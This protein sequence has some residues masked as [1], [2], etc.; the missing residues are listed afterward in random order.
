MKFELLTEEEHGV[1][2]KLAEVFGD[3]LDIINKSSNGNAH[4]SSRGPDI[5]EVVNHIHALQN[6]VLAQ[7]AARRYPDRYRLLGSSIIG[8]RKVM[9]MLFNEEKARAFSVDSLDISIRAKNRLSTAK[10]TTVGDLLNLPKDVLFNNKRFEARVLWE[11]EA[12]LGECFGLTLGCS[13]EA[14]RE[15]KKR[16]RK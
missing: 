3:M 14:R 11:L 16:K 9:P 10:V 4:D 1:V 7:A 15:W 6:M 13:P 8:S 12:V 5:C 2:K